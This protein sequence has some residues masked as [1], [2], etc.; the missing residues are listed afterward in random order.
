MTQT[1]ENDDENR[2]TRP[3]RRAVKVGGF[4]N[5]ETY[6]TYATQGSCVK[7]YATHATHVTYTTQRS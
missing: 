1:R 2:V 6:A 3:I 4:L 7:F 5:Y